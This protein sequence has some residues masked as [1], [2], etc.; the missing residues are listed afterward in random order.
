MSDQASPGSKL[1]NSVA[2]TLIARGAMI[3]ATVVGLPVAGFMLQRGVNTV[4][5]VSQKI[6][7]MRNQAFETNSTVKL[8]QQTQGMQTQIIA[9][10]EARVRT[11][12]NQGRRVT[13]Q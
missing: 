2:L 1:V 6:D 12:E 3:L 5:E 13:P 7:T 9:D 8:I 4:D 11:L 10:H